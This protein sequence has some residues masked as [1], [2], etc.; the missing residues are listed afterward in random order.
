MTKERKE[1]VGGLA[2][3]V[4]VGILIYLFSG[5]K[6]WSVFDRHACKEC[7]G[8]GKASMDC[9]ACSGRGTPPGR[10]VP[11][12]PGAAGRNRF[13]GSAP[14]PAGSR[15]GPKADVHSLARAIDDEPWVGHSGP[16]R[17]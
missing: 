17:G 1:M 15:D 9:R 2:A 7:W 10:D 5:C 16:A 8:T 4:A 11:R 3:L 6:V 14:G 12:A 13:A